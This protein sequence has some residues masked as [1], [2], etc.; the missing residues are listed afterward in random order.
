M[1]ASLFPVGVVT[2]EIDP[3]SVK[4]C[5]YPEEE[6]FVRNAVAKRRMEF[7]AGRVCARRALS[8]LGI[9]DFPI[10]TNEDRT[11]AWPPGIVGSITHAEG[12]CGAAVARTGEFESIGLDA[13]CV[14]KL[15]RDNW[16][17]IC[18]NRELSWIESLPVTDQ[19]QCVALIFSAKE[20][21]YKLQYTLRREWLGFHDIAISPV[22]GSAEFEVKLLVDVGRR[23]PQG[24]RLGGRY[25]F[26]RGLVLTGLALRPPA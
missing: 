26:R 7:R 10:V 9:R 19:E 4:G 20:S 18:T 2:E 5:L 1:I 14:G 6:I 3:H 12:Y 25:L 17:H 23:L 21:F 22:K 13:E 16:D 24:E 15:D 8:R 11:P